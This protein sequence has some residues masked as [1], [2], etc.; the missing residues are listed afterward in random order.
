MKLA[1]IRIDRTKSLGNYEN[2]KLGFTVIV[3]EG[4]SAVEAIERAKTLV[5]WEINRE[6]RERL[7][8][9]YSVKIA[10]LKAKAQKSDSPDPKA[11]AEIIRL[12]KWCDKFDATRSEI[13]A[14]RW[15]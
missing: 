10:D 12:Q 5:D 13:E 8:A 14:I 3:Q 1:E 7:Y 15:N 9:E 11:D 6:E 2:L 4:E